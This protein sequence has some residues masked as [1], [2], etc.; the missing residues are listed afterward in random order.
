MAFAYNTSYPEGRDKE[1]RGSKPALANSSQDLISKIPKTKKELAEWL[2][3][4]RA[5]L[6]SVGS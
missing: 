6:A 5:N 1:D 4:W 2:S 3:W